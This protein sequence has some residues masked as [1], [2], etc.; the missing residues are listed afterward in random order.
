MFLFKLSVNVSPPMHQICLLLLV[1]KSLTFRKDVQVLFDQIWLTVASPWEHFEDFLHLLMEFVS[2]FQ[3]DV[4]LYYQ[5][6]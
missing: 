5:D 4:Q 2:R 6:F 1:I 3:R